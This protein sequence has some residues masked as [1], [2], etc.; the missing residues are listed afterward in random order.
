[1]A[2]QGL[3][4]M[5]M[6][7]L[8]YKFSNSSLGRFNAVTE[9]LVI[10]LGFYTWVAFSRL[11]QTM[12]PV[13]PWT[14]QKVNFNFFKFF[15][16]LLGVGEN[17]FES[18][19]QNKLR[20]P[21]RSYYQNFRKNGKITPCHFYVGVH[22][23]PHLHHAFLKERDLRLWPPKTSILHLKLFYSHFAWLREIGNC[24]ICVF[25]VLFQFQFQFFIIIHCLSK[26]E[27][28]EIQYNQNT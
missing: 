16:L 14:C 8:H 3:M 28:T 17:E 7:D 2:W 5:M 23:G 18:H 26:R 21:F 19:S 15:V 9:Q 25:H 6:M 4:M 12:E 13:W 10:V 11:G 27:N 24:L 20:W 1:M 22:P